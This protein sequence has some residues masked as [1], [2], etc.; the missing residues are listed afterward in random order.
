[1]GAQRASARFAVADAVR[2]YR[3]AIDAHRG[4]LT[5]PE[6]LAAV[7]EALGE[8]LMAVGEIPDA[9]RALGAARRLFAG[10]PVAEA[11]ICF[12]RGQIAEREEMSSAVRWIRRGLR[13]VEQRAG[14]D[15]QRWR[16]RLIAELAWIRQRQRRYRDAERLCREALEVGEA[17]GDLRAQARASYTLDWALIELGRYDEAT[18]STRALE[19]Y[20]EL[21]DP[22]QEGR[23]LNNLGAFAYWRGRWSEAID[24]YERAGTCS[25]RAGHAADLAFTD[26][27]IGEILSDQGHLDA[28]ADRL[29]R[30]HRVWNATGDRQGSAYANMLLGRVAVRDGRAAEGLGLLRDAVSDLERLHVDF[31]ADL[32]HSLI[33]EGEA[34]GGDASRALALAGEH[35]A[36]GS[37]Y[38]S[39]LRRV[40]G[41]ALLRLGEGARAQEELRLA[42]AE[43]RSRDEDYDVALALDALAA[44]GAAADDELAERA[45]ILERLGVDTVPG[46]TMSQPADGSPLAATSRG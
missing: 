32:A 2:L 21:G 12:R 19:I 38:V 5:T 39:L 10:E 24:L 3:R 13:A 27:N 26:A 16:A 20:R 44:T 42:A 25:E 15:G 46:V 7:W 14:L 17:A 30:A 35:L 41:I 33:A 1:M 18:H 11:R 23:V 45:A 37:R 6:E 36:S 29:R 31:Y 4:A 28:A 34:L 8:A 43:A 9:E 22:E 40:R